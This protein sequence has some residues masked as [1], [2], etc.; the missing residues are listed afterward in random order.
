MTK[1]HI[2]IA[3][4]SSAERSTGSVRDRVQEC[5]AANTQAF[6]EAASV[7]ARLHYGHAA[8]VDGT[9]AVKSVDGVTARSGRAAMS[10]D[11]ISQDG[12]SDICRE[13]SGYVEFSYAVEGDVL[14][15]DWAWPDQPST[16]DEF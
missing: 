10:F 1:R 2:D 5:L 7:W 3:M 4:E 14:K 12:C 11:W 8:Y 13:G 6:A 9:L 16:V 15:V